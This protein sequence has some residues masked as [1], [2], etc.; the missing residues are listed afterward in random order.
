MRRCASIV[1][2]ILVAAATVPAKSAVPKLDTAAVDALVVKQMKAAGTPGVSLAIVRNGRVVYARGYG[3]VSLATRAPVSSETTFAIGSIS[4]Q[5]LAAEVLALQAQ[6]RMHLTDRLSRYYPHF[7][8]GGEITIADLLSH[9]A[10]IRDYYPLDYND[11]A[12]SGPTTMAAI[13][14]RA[15]TQ[16]LDFAPRTAWQYSN[17]GYSVAGAIVE[18][19]TGQTLYELYRERL[20]RPLGM[21]S[22]Q[23]NDSAA[24]LPGEAVGYSS[25]F[26]GPDG[27]AVPEGPGWRNAAASL[28]MTAP[29]LARWTIALMDA[30]VL[31]EAQMKT[32]WTSRRLRDGSDPHYGL[33]VG[34]SA[35]GR[36]PLIEHGGSISGFTSHELMLPEM[37]AAVVV[38]SNDS[39]GVSSSIARAILPM[40]AD[41]PPLENNLAPAAGVT[42]AW[43]RAISAGNLD[44]AQLTADFNAFMTP[45]RVAAAAKALGA[46]GEPLSAHLERSYERGGL[47]ADVLK[48]TYP[49]RVVYAYLHRRRDGKIAELFIAPT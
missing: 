30:R 6:G 22:A 20:F 33:G 7:P 38:L 39:Y 48:V 13:A 49:H 15:A 42:L 31:T 40:L 10:G 17:T 9:E 12:M 21:H 1:F 2:A 32:L 4:K 14:A 23:W 37:H 34:V 25:F 45:G 3:V 35:Y 26:L 46:L 8:S 5:F 28:V 18:R 44:R 24:R 47:T 16:P 29:D 27:V 43:L 19:V 11:I 41:P 36:V